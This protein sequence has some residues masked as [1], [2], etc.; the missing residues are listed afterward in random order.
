[1]T[2]RPKD[3][4]ATQLERYGMCHR[5]TQFYTD[6]GAY[7]EWYLDTLTDLL[8]EAD[9]PTGDPFQCYTAIMDYVKEKESKVVELDEHRDVA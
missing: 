9:I 1:M 7:R 8:E 3:I 6:Y 4:I 5:N 2:D